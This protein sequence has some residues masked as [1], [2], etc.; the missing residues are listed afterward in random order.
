MRY[1]VLCCFLGIQILT[2]QAPYPKDTY[3]PPLD[4]PLVLA[5]NF[6]E[7]R[8]NHFHAGLDIKTQQRQGLKVYAIADGYVSRIKVQHYGYGKVLYITHS[9]GRTSAYAH[10][11]KFAPEIEKFLKTRQYKKKTYAIDLYLEPSDLRIKQG[12]VIAYSGNTGSSAG[13]HL[14]FEIR[15]AKQ[16]PL[17]PLHFG[18]DVQDTQAPRIRQLYVYPMAETTV[19]N[20]AQHKIPLRL[21]S[22][23]DGSLVAEKIYTT[24]PIGLGVNAY[25]RQDLAY[26]KNGVYQIDLQVNGSPHYSYK[27]D[28]FSFG[29]SRYINTLIDY[30]HLEEKGERIQK[31]FREPFNK[32]SF[33]PEDTNNGLIDIKEGSSY[34]L[35]LTL[36]DFHGNT[37]TITIPAEGKTQEIRRKKEETVPP[38]YV[39]ASRDNL[40]QLDGGSVF[41]PEGTFYHNF[42]AEI[43][44]DEEGITVADP[45]IAVKSSYTLT[46]D[47]KGT[48]PSLTDQYFIGRI[49][50]K[51]RV[52]YENTYKKD[53]D[54]STRTRSLGRF[55]L[56][57]DSVAPE[58][59]P[60]NFRNNQNL[61]NFRYLKLR[62]KDDLSGISSFEGK[63]DDQWILLEY[64]YKNGSLTFNFDDLEFEGGKHNL[65]VIVKDNVGNSTTFKTS[66]YRN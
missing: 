48:D 15:D 5:G 64:E 18:Y 57:R 11:Q 10:L 20:G 44:A 2:A 17:N 31:C 8:S 36:R 37:T 47:G 14:H 53:G 28:S 49:D 12:E 54:F 30:A 41:F 13:P 40:Y 59:K 29:E 34:S 50:D 55:A 38:Y 25:D 58:V 4:V 16:H 46:I 32:L 21:S 23:E 27:F 35:L 62:I 7:L 56:V 51:G 24:G 52:S 65:E 26:N 45:A 19:V 42:H 6:G 60:A 39:I 9:D 43:S 22:N 3:I 66:F 33:L 61:A 1:L 63:I